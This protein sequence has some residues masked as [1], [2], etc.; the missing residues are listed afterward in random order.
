MVTAAWKYYSTFLF[1][2]VDDA[3][4]LITVVTLQTPRYMVDRLMGRERE[5]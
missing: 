4:H 5:M 1:S 3:G 2:P